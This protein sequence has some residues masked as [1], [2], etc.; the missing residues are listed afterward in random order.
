MPIYLT[1]TEIEQLIQERKQLPIDYRA[2]VQ[3]R[4]KRGHKER[5]IDVAGENGGRFRLILRQGELN[6]L[7]FSIILA[8]LPPGSNQVFR[9][10]RYNGKSH[11]HSNAIEMRTFYDFHIHQATSRYQQLGAREDTF[12]VRT[13]RFSD[14]SSALECLLLD[15]AFD[16]PPDPQG[17]LF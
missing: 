9:L 16:V 8:Y 1:D 14:F 15:C 11:E 17:A 3:V 7:D 5:E 4:P 10:C 6:P 2:K 12:A 13:D